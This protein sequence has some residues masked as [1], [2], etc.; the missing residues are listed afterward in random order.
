MFVSTVSATII[1][2]HPSVWAIVLGLSGRVSSS[3]NRNLYT[4]IYT[5]KYETKLP[6]GLFPLSTARTSTINLRKRA[7]MNL[8]R[9]EQFP[10][11]GR[12]IPEFP[13]LPYREVLVTPF[14]F[15]YLVKGKT[16]WIVAVWHEARLPAE[17]ASESSNPT[18][19]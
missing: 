15:F 9:L 7:E 2:S 10:E 1:C 11:S 5:Y 13:E 6:L 14:R 17:P 19:T 4:Y 8:R 3:D 12:V 16:V 18:Q